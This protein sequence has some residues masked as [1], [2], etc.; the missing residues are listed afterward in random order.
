MKTV[1]VTIDPNDPKSIAIGRIDPER[2][3]A[4]LES[5][6]D[7]HSPTALFTL[8]RENSNDNSP[9]TAD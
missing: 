8:I 6:N 5:D 2:V 3:D 7:N 1:Q 4:M 9:L